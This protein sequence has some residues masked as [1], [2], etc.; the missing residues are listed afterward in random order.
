MKGASSTEGIEILE[1]NLVQERSREVNPR[2]NNPDERPGN[3]PG[4]RA[5]AVRA[6]EP[7]LQWLVQA[8]QGLPRVRN[9]LAQR[10]MEQAAAQNSRSIAGAHVQSAL[11]LLPWLAEL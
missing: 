5:F 9:H 11:Q 7:A 3:Q 8:A 4:Q 1:V 10:A 6:E 2:G